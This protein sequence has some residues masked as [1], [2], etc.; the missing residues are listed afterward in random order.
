MQYHH[1]IHFSLAE[2]RAMIPQIAVA[3]E[4][5]KRLKRKLDK[6][7]YDLRAHQYFTRLGTNGTGP[8]PAEVDQLIA[9]HRQLVTQGIQVKDIDRGLIDFPSI[10]ENGEEVYLCYML[11]EQTIE[12]W[13]R[14]SDGFAGRQPIDSL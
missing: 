9:L 10:R 7:G 5:M 13:H 6:S 12:H 3:L 14:I 1:L 8:Y 4:E 11:G 2:A